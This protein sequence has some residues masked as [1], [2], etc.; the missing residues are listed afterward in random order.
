MIP[1]SVLDL[2]PIPRGSDAA[3][4]F[5]NTL[6]LAQHAEQWGYQ[7]YWL[8]E[9]HNMTGIAS[10]ATAVVIGHVAG[11]TKTMRVGA[12]GVMLPNHAPLV[13]AEQFGTLASLYPGRIDLGLGRAPGT[14]MMTARALRRDLATNADM[15]P[16]DVV[17]LQMYFQP[18]EPGQKIRA[19]PGAGLDVPIWLLGSSLFS[20][21]LAAALGLPFA[22]ASHFAPEQMSAALELYRS[23]FKPSEQLDRPYAMV[24][25]NVFAAET[26]AEA[27][28]LFTSAQQQFVNLRRGEPGPLPPPV[29][30]MEGRWSAMEKAGV[31]RALACS[32]VGSPATVR[33]GLETFLAATKPEEII[34]TG[35]IY[36]HA[37][38]LRSFEI[39]ADIHKEIAAG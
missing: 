27:Q 37:A 24:G 20:A 39:A 18:A 15:F 26:D 22:F 30:T 8:A 32:M 34:V 29:D 19:V 13:I 3:Q 4:A 2:A 38:R 17:E 16:Q 12:G 14:D 33:R 11:G 5:R 25:V 1:F 21:Q 10:A 35:Q 36:D 7:R 9:H 6:D 23:Q 28:R 31:E